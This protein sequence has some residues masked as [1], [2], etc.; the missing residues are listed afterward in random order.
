MSEKTPRE[1]L[2][3]TLRRSAEE[4]ESLPAWA[5]IALL[6]RRTFEKKHGTKARWLICDCDECVTARA[7][8]DQALAEERAQRE[9]R[10][11]WHEEAAS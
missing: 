1:Q 7:P 2:Q 3:D 6:G 11:K 8:L 10:P 5:R 4:V 9:A